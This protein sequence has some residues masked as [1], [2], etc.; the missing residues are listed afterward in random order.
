MRLCS[1]YWNGAGWRFSF[2]FLSDARLTCFTTQITH[3]FCVGVIVFCFDQS[4]IDS[5]EYLSST[6]VRKIVGA[7]DQSKAENANLSVPS[8]VQPES[9]ASKLS[10]SFFANFIVFVDLRWLA[11]IR[12][13]DEFSNDMLR[14]V[15]CRGSISGMCSHSSERF[16]A[17]RVCLT[18]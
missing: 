9:G 14:A 10:W 6:V 8:L 5:C 3:F 2:D 18:P 12:M 17:Q 11:N 15:P 7:Y 13:V 1:E 16:L 4:Y